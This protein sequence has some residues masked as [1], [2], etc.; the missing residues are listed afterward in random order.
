MSNNGHRHNPGSLKQQ[1]K[2][3]KHGVHRSKHQLNKFGK[4]NTTKVHHKIVV[5]SKKDRQNEKK[6]KILQNVRDSK[7][8]LREV[9]F[10]QS[11]IPI[12]VISSS[13]FTCEH[14]VSAFQSD[15]NYEVRSDWINKNCRD[16]YLIESS[17]LKKKLL[18]MKM[19]QDSAYYFHDT[20]YASQAIWILMNESDSFAE[21]SALF[22]TFDSFNTRDPKR[23]STFMEKYSNSLGPF[24]CD[25]D[26]IIQIH[27]SINI[28][29]LTKCIPSFYMRP[30]S[31]TRPEKSR[32]NVNIISENIKYIDSETGGMLIVEGML[33]GGCL[34]AND[35]VVI[36]GFGNFPIYQ[37]QTSELENKNHD[38]KILSTRTKEFQLAEIDE[39]QYQTHDDTDHNMEC[40]DIL[41]RQDHQ[42]FEP[43]E[44]APMDIDIPEYVQNWPDYK[45]NNE[46]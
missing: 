21:M 13:S 39:G 34:S 32:K 30:F 46:R 41:M 18:M 24:I 15:G 40:E 37:I 20:I 19:T 3:H 45:D 23:V 33:R 35:N 27:D 6:T 38:T 43:R 10:S 5:K 42:F 11:H 16:Y 31:S 17:R 36:P 25:S 28:H 26:N 7:D 8:F 2:K 12:A 14:L 1:N 44:L 29:K 9:G 22:Q 4:Q